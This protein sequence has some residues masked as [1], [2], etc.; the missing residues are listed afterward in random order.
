MIDKKTILADFCRSMEITRDARFQAN[1]RLSMRDRSSSYVI[2]LLST[3]VIFLSLIPNF[4]SL[5]TFQSQLLL[6][7]SIILSV[8]IIFTSLLDSSSKFMHRGELLHVCARGTETVLKEARVLD[9]ESNSFFDLLDLLK[10]RYQK[11]LDDCPV[12]HD[13]VD[14]LK[15]RLQKPRL[16]HGRH[17]SGKRWIYW[18]QRLSDHLRY[19][20]EAWAWII[21]HLCA[22]VIVILVLNTFVFGHSKPAGS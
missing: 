17:Y 19:R 8:F 13:N 22:V 7:C 9:T 18:T 21:P 2:A 16:F 1:I 12:N 3:L 11:I 6:A 10:Q 15:A 4:L 5:T 14:Y 20:I